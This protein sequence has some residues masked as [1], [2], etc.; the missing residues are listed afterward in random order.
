M[1]E[2]EKKDDDTYGRVRFDSQAELDRH[3][4]WSM[5]MNDENKYCDLEPDQV[6]QMISEVSKF[7]M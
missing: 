4:S 6:K 7:A 3:K 5:F 1:I 2:E